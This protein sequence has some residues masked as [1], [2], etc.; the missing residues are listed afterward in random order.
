[1]KQWIDKG[2]SVL[3]VALDNKDATLNRRAGLHGNSERANEHVEAFSQAAL[4]EEKVGGHSWL[5]MYVR[6]LV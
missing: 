4:A 1:M 5:C 2:A 3:G 6:V